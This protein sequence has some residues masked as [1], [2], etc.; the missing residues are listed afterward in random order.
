M[1]GPSSNRNTQRRLSAFTQTRTGPATR[2]GVREIAALELDRATTKSPHRE[3]HAFPRAVG[4]FVL[5]GEISS[6][7]SD[8]QLVRS[9]FHGLLVHERDDILKGLANGRVEVVSTF[10]P[11]TCVK[12]VSEIYPER[13]I[14]LG[15]I[16]GLRGGYK[17][18]PRVPMP[19]R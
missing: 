12:S 4:P 15:A 1:G 13:W 3:L 14:R 18:T 19:V 10:Q 11:I 2:R 9:L 5:D 7:G 17:P 6:G 8:F 16:R